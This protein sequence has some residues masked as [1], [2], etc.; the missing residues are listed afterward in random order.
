MKKENE[1]AQIL[2]SF[3]NDQNIKNN[4]KKSVETKEN[5]NKSMKIEEENI[6]SYNSKKQKAE[7]LENQNENLLEK[8]QNLEY[9]FQKLEE[10]T[11]QKNVEEFC[12]KFKK[13]AQKNYDLFLTI[14]MISK[15]AKQ[16]EK[17]IRDLEDEIETIK[18]KK[19]T[20]QGVEKVSLLKELKSK[21]QKLIQKQD[22]YEN[23]SKKKLDEFKAI[24][25]LIYN[26]YSIM[27]CMEISKET[28]KIIMNKGVNES[29]TILFLSDIET[30]LKS[31][32]KCFELEK[33]SD[34]L[35]ETK[36]KP[37][38]TIKDRLNPRHINDQMKLFFA[39]LDISKLKTFEKI[40]L[41]QKPDE[42]KFENIFEFSNQVL[43][44]LD[45]TVRNNQL[46][47]KNNKFGMK[48]KM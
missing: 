11:G 17:E 40:K 44:E 6:I 38:E 36:V 24:K 37:N 18:K 39:N 4:R 42:I 23:E 16:L 22:K 43:F 2:T 47:R 14:S 29:N 35:Q 13:N 27:D 45:E 41:N 25:G 26:V 10:F 5:T 28:N 8:L 30:R 3:V 12:S 21:T 48:K 34:D 19:K 46:G 1:Y 20:V 9:K 15:Q 32:K 33:A 7:I 31:I